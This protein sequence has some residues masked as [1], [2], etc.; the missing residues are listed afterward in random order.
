M[1]YRELLR[2]FRPPAPS[3]FAGSKVTDENGA[4]LLVYHGTYAKFAKFGH[5]RDNGFT[6]PR[7]GYYFTDTLEAAREFGDAHGYYLSIQ[8]PADFSDWE[9]QEHV[10]KALAADPELAERYTTLVSE[11][12]GPGVSVSRLQ[13]MGLLQ[14]DQFLNA[15]IKTGCDGMFMPDDFAGHDFISYIAF[16][17]SQIRRVTRKP[18]PSPS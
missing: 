12:Y 6:K 17:P 5:G 18:I 16:K 9:G 14:T 7:M 10:D 4:A 8:H 2:E 13:R 3:W 15:L 1:R 11:R